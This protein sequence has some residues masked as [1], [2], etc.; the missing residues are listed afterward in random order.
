MKKVTKVALPPT[1]PLMHFQSHGSFKNSVMF[2]LVTFCS[3]EFGSTAL[4]NTWAL[5]DFFVT[6]AESKQS[7]TI[8]SK[9]HLVCIF[10]L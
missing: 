7:S 2:L 1:S 5:L 8:N 3:K 4:D 6:A 9:S 10:S